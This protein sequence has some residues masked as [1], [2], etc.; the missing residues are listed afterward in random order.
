MAF[1][2]IIAEI[3]VSRH[4]KIRKLGVNM[5]ADKKLFLFSGLILVASLVL[6]S[7]CSPSGGGASSEL[8][9]RVTE[10]ESKAKAHEQAIANLQ[11]LIEAQK[12]RI[13]ALT[14][15]APAASAPATQPSTPSTTNKT[16]VL[17]SSSI[18]FD[19][20]TITPVQISVGGTVTITIDVKNTGPAEGTTK[21]VLI[22]M[23][24][25]PQAGSNGLEYAST[26]TLTPGETQ[27]V[28]FTATRNAA[29][30]YSVQVGGKT[31]SYIVN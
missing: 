12:T 13:D 31:G 19:K 9:N 8:D 17:A 29:G 27:T 23:M 10:L 6:L 1:S 28:T 15:A 22:D 7:G 11:Q 24:T 2:C 21:V 3:C 20:L 5:R 16:A 4:T 26:V 30:T 25:S 14:P 18:A